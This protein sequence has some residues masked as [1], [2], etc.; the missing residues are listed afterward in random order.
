MFKIQIVDETQM[1]YK[2]SDC[3]KCKL[4]AKRHDKLIANAKKRNE[5]LKKLIFLQADKNEVK[6]YQNEIAINNVK[7]QKWIKEG[8]S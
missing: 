5:Q 3:M 4:G 2:E 7:I 6:R 1:I 8:L